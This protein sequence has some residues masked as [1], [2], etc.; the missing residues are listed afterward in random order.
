MANKP[1]PG[2]YDIDLE[3][4]GD[5]VVVSEDAIRLRVKVTREAY[6]KKISTA[7]GTKKLGSKLSYKEG[8]IFLL[9]FKD[10]S[11]SRTNSNGTYNDDLLLRLWANF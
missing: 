2:Y 3:V 7:V 1:T 5:K 10:I 9:F 4:T 11:I 6:I 8:S